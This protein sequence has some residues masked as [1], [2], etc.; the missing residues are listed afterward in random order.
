MIHLPQSASTRRKARA[1]DLETYAQ[2]IVQT[3]REPLLILDTTL[4]VRSANR[5]FYQTF[6]VSPQETENRLI[7]ELGNGQWDIPALRTLLEDVI[8][9]SSVFNDFELEHTFPRIGRRVMLLN[10]RKLRAG[11]HAELLVLAIED[12]TERRRTEADLKAIETYAQNIV[13]T[14]REP[15]L[16]LDTTL[17][18]RSANRAFYE[19]FRVTPEETEARLIYELGNGQ[20]DI[21]DLR[22][23]LED[24]VPR[25]SVF[26]DFEL[27]HDFP[28]IGRRVMLLNARKLQAGH[29]G[30]LLVLAMEDVTERRRAEEE[31]ARARE[32]AETANKTKSLFLANMSHE[33]RTP[34]NAILGYSEMLC[35]EA[36]ERELDGFGAD[37]EKIGSAGRHLL[38]LINDILDLSKI[39]AGKMELFLERFE[40]AEL[41][42]EVASTIRPMVETNG[43]TLRLDLAPDLG[44]MHADQMKVRQ[45]LFNLLSNAVKFTRD[46][47][48]T[49]TA[50]REAR[51]G[52]EW[53]VFRVADTG[54][55]LSEEQIV[56]LFQDFSQ[57]DASTTRR[58]GGTGLGLALTRR[59]CQMMG[60]DVTV[61]SVE[62]EGSVF[63]IRLPASVRDASPEPAVERSPAAPA[64]AEAA[65]AEPPPPGSCV[66]VIDDEPVQRDLMQRFLRRE[67]FV[68]QAAAGGEEGLRLARRL[69]PAAIT[70]DVMMP[71]MDGW[72]V[73]QALK[74]DPALRDIPVVMLTML[75][76]PARG[77]ALGAA[78][79]ATKPVS[80]ERLSRILRKHTCP[81]PPCPVLMVEDDPVARA[82]TRNILEKEGWKVSEAEN[83]VAALECLERQRPSL[84]LLDLLMPEMDGF[85]FAERVRRHPEWRSIPIVVL[86]SKELSGEER[87]RLDGYVELI[88]K[89]DGDTHEALLLQVR[90]LLE[91]WAAPREAA[92]ADGGERRSPVPRRLPEAP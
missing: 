74:A 31:V 79:Y 70:L 41:I 17:R 44:E 39:E 63:T 9:T 56:R 16:I 7:Y 80:R 22:T 89:K 32:A 68:V 83:G 67:G 81:H 72:S 19:T 28:A 57:A 18:A 76:D 12:V 33:L 29:H 54:I 13:D 26:N 5:A 58:F 61:H 87:R 69:R 36:A 65:G 49:V 42:G 82:L 25:S 66:L 10:G 1:Q 64:L 38:A 35:E 53:I 62:G 23:L 2:D 91:E 77:F 21:P 6:R 86:S 37:L 34:L 46:G 59:F 85:E 75:D 20:W 24:I 48:V 84:I 52:R 90:D 88:L 43:N 11:S 51:G 45:G 92:S 4:R 40:V 27:E 78:D 47:S 3:V 30:E 8:P 15:L 14:V 50:A 55:G 71:D 73:L 60:G